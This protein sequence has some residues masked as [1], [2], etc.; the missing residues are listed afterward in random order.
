MNVGELVD[1]ETLPYTYKIVNSSIFS[2]AY[3]GDAVL[4]YHC[5]LLARESRE[6]KGLVE[7]GEEA[8]D[9]IEKWARWVGHL[10]PTAP[11]RGC[12]M[13]QVLLYYG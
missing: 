11:R 5:F 6:S 2:S 8:L 9:D 1:D 12:E 3:Y 13:L 10:S 7:K 4:S